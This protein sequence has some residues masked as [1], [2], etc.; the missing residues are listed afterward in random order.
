MHIHF[1]FIG[2]IRE[3]HKRLWCSPIIS[4]Y[5]VYISTFQW[6]ACMNCLINLLNPIVLKFERTYKKCKLLQVKNSS[7]DSIQLQSASG[8]WTPIAALRRFHRARGVMFGCPA[9]MCDHDADK[10]VWQTCV[11]C[12]EERKWLQCE[13]CEELYCGICDCPDANP[14]DP[15][16]ITVRTS[17][18]KNQSSVLLSPDYSEG[19]NDAQC[20]RMQIANTTSP[21]GCDQSRQCT[22]T[23]RRAGATGRH[24]ERETV[25][26]NT[27]V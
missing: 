16:P 25:R 4:H 17:Q 3:H 6:N 12:H 24:S 15:P 9:G 11:F 26:T 14:P 7:R 18:K 10:H 27:T 21:T 19:S 20:R 13:Y 22:L 5:F 8:I 1:G 2:A 23:R